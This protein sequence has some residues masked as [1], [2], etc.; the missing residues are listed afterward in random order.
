[1]NGYLTDEEKTVLEYT[2]LGGDLL[3]CPVPLCSRTLYLK[4]IS[5]SES[6]AATF[7]MSGETLAR[8]HAEQAVKDAARQ[9]MRH[10][11]KHTPAEWLRFCASTVAILEVASPVDER[12]EQ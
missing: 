8:I 12:S 10:L 1:M 9:M 11:E 7:G 5:V 4:P 6:V 3:H 2:M